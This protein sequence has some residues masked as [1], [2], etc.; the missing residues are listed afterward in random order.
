MT[1]ASRFGAGSAP[2]KSG[3]VGE[4]VTETGSPIH[5]VHPSPPSV[6]EALG[7][8]WGCRS[9][10]RIFVWRDVRIRYRHTM[11]G[12]AWNVVQPLGMA[13][14][15]TFVFGVIFNAP[16]RDVPYPVFLFPAIILWQTFAK[17]L[18]GGGTSL[19]LYAGV[20]GK[21]YFPR[22]IAP[23]AAIVGATIDLLVSG[24]ALV[25]L[26]ALYGVWPTWHVV[27][28]PVFVLLTLI[29][30]MGLAVWLTALDSNYKDIRHTLTFVTQFWLFATPVMYPISM[31][32]E[33]LVPLY[34][35]NPMVGLVQGFRFSLVPG[36]DP[37]TVAMVAWSALF[38]V[39]T[40]VTGVR[41]FT[42]REG[43]LVD[44]V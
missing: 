24:V 3:L 16:M 15:F 1:T 26:M 32:P 11:L 7:E 42:A 21:V 44:T 2:P 10:L 34:S 41:Y 6:W 5:F 30:G 43:V 27:F 4:T 28:A 29:V 25:S 33:R 22:L 12:A 14:V 17:C 35:L 37:P 18:A 38:G 20:L 39:V 40:L 13:A 8:L 31:V 36:V 23:T 19:E 9:T